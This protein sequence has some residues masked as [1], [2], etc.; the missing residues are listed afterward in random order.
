MFL[1]YFYFIFVF[2]GYVV[3]DLLY[4][5][6]MW[7]GF[8][9]A[10]FASLLVVLLYRLWVGNARLGSCLRHTKNSRASIPRGSVVSGPSWK[11][12]IGDHAQRL[13]KYVEIS[14]ICFEDRKKAWKDGDVDLLTHSQAHQS[15]TIGISN[16]V[17]ILLPTHLTAH[18]DCLASLI[19]SNLIYPIMFSAI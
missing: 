8:A 4:S 12:H 3:S 19:P 14:W 17:E 10:G 9:F 16:M 5:T 7:G 1:A 18:S 15:S 2:A 13:L 11:E 6:T